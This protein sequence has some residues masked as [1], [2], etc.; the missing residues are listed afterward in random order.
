M[1]FDLSNHPYIYNV[2]YHSF[3]EGSLCVLPFT[4]T[5]YARDFILFNQAKRL[6]HLFGVFSNNFPPQSIS[7]K[8]EIWLQQK[9]VPNGYWK[10]KENQLQYMNWLSQKLNI[11]T[12]EDWYNVSQEVTMNH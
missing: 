8:Q 11:K 12:M 9:K 10:V 7:A 6:F 2:W 1:F 3:G 4:A 5:L